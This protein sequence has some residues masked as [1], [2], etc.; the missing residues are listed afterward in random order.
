MWALVQNGGQQAVS[1]VVFLALARFF[2]TKEEFGLVA[3]ASLLIVFLNVLVR[4][5]L[6]TALIQRREID[7]EHLVTTFWA[8]VSLAI[9]LALLVVFLAGPI[10]GLLGD[11]RIVSI[12]QVMSIAVV[13]TSLGLTQEAILSRK[14]LFKALAI[15]AIAA[16]SAGGVAGLV[17]AAMGGGVWALVTMNITNALVGVLVLWRASQWRPGLRFYPGKLRELMGVS[18]GVFGVGLVGYF[19]QFVD[20]IV[21]GT[22]LG[23]SALGIYYVGNRI[24]KAVMAIST[25]SLVSVSL[26]GFSAVQDDM[27]RLRRGIMLAVSMTALVGFPIFSLL[28]VS[29]SEV[30][31]VILGDKWEAAIPIMSWLAAAAMIYSV[32]NFNGSILIAL[33][34]S[35][36]SLMM[37]ILA[38]VIL[39]IFSLIGTGFGL[40]GVAIAAFLK[41][42][43]MLPI[44]LFVLRRMAGI[45][46]IE[47]LRLLAIPFLGSA[48]AAGCYLA[49]SK[50][51]AGFFTWSEFITLIAGTSIWFI[52]YIAIVLMLDRTRVYGLFNRIFHR[53]APAGSSSNETIR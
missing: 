44:W 30:T 43:V 34:H 31:G 1:T 18:M 38:T 23:P 16:A 2:L 42:T 53:A 9:L 13:L 10:A 26:P 29:A 32:Q 3:L 17:V 37:S 21:V 39:V 20:Q 28:M 27:E 40:E 14:F 33:G 48:I 35:R 5:G 11:T 36:Q 51:A 25:N 6:G 46:V 7:D 45:R 22:L 15:R 47:Y 19:N 49:V 8:N 41:A 12:L 50:I 52:S 4:Q 24:I